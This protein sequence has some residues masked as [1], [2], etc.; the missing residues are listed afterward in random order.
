M[1]LPRYAGSMLL[2]APKN[3]IS[4]YVLLIAAR[5]TS[6]RQLVGATLVELMSHATTLLRYGGSRSRRRSG[7][8][9][10]AVQLVTALSGLHERVLVVLRTA[11]VF[12]APAACCTAAAVLHSMLDSV[13][14]AGY[15]SARLADHVLDMVENPTTWWLLRDAAKAW[16]NNWPAE[17]RVADADPRALHFALTC[18]S[19]PKWSAE[20]AGCPQCTANFQARSWQR[21][22]ARRRRLTSAADAGRGWRRARSVRCPTWRACC[23]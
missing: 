10:G 15:Q 14:V 3:T 1:L 21:S 23:T 11:G 13:H 5:G 4:P 16:H 18:S 9:V 12:A 20:R 6:V 22:L 2:W 7:S 8:Q 19:A 17:W